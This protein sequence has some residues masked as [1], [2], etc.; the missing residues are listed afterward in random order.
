MRM[1][2]QDVPPGREFVLADCD[3]LNYDIYISLDQSVYNNSDPNTVLCINTNHP[4][5]LW[6]IK[7][8]T[9]VGA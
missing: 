5:A 4:Q 6:G 2:V 7:I 1:L 8:N 3:P 9:E